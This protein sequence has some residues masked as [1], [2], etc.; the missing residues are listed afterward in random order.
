VG[1]SFSLPAPNRGFR[2]PGEIKKILVGNYFKKRVVI[3]IL[4]NNEGLSK[5]R[6]GWKNGE[7]I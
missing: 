3:S 6:A 7:S 5:G 1:L 2:K 4:P